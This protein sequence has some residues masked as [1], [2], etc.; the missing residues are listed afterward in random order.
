M[1]PRCSPRL[2]LSRL[3]ALCMLWCSVYVSMTFM[4]R[5]P[6]RNYFR[7]MGIGVELGNGDKIP[8]YSLVTSPY[9]AVPGLPL[10]YDTRSV[11][12]YDDLCEAI[13]RALMAADHERQMVVAVVD[14]GFAFF[15]GPLA[16]VAIVDVPEDADVDGAGP[17]SLAMDSIGTP[18]DLAAARRATTLHGAAGASGAASGDDG[19]QR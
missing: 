16:L 15:Q 19:Q 1:L 14:Q 9:R 7:P 5:L 8:L 12:N 17:S 10:F 18:Y 2:P 11:E 6:R 4:P 13:R 3:T